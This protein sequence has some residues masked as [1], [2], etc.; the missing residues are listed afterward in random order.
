MS[1]PETEDPAFALPLPPTWALDMA[2]HMSGFREWFD[3]PVFF[4]TPINRRVIVNA[5]LIA[6]TWTS[7]LAFECHERATYL[8]A[9]E[10]EG[11]STIELQ[12]MATL[13]KAASEIERLTRATSDS[14]THPKG[15]DLKQAPFMGSAGP[16]G[17]AHD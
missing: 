3:V 16:K 6:R 2:A 1:G 8:K 13:F 5:R 11:L 7:P 9:M 15:G 10:P 14:D 4:Q 17:I 12:S